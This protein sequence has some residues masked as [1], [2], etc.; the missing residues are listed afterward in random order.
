MS[1]MERF[2]KYNKRIQ[3]TLG[4]QTQQQQRTT[5]MPDHFVGQR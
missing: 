1:N 2:Y 4:K 5:N 3:V